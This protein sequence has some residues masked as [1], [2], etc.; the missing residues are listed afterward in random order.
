MPKERI[1]RIMWVFHSRGGLLRRIS[2]DTTRKQM[3]DPQLERTGWYLR[4]F[5]NGEIIGW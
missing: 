4:D 1:N 3:I 2:E 5:S